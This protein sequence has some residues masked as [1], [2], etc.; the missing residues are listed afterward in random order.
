MTQ[1]PIVYIISVS[2]FRY[3]LNPALRIYVC[4]ENRKGLLLT[5]DIDK[6]TRMFI[7]LYIHWK[8]ANT[9]SIV[10]FPL[11]DSPMRTINGDISSSW[12][13]CI[14]PRFRIIKLSLFIVQHAL[15]ISMQIYH[16]FFEQSSAKPA[17]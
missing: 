4:H 6:Y 14:G 15:N 5:P 8:R 16:I 17:I 12:T 7:I 13:S 1:L 3:F 10:L 2:G 11:P 9:L